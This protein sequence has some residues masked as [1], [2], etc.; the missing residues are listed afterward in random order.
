MPPFSAT[1]S[2]DS[3]IMTPCPASIITTMT[4]SILMPL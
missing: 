3:D 4:G 2:M 1:D